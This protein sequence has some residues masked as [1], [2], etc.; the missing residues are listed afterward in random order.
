MLSVRTI[1]VSNDSSILIGSGEY[2]NLTH[3]ASQGVAKVS[4]NNACVPLK[5]YGVK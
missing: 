3:V 1:K 4:T 2:V 5:I